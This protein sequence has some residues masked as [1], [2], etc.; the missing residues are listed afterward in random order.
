MKKSNSLIQ[1]FS[2]SLMVMQNKIECMS[3]GCF[4]DQK[5]QTVRLVTTPVE[6]HTIPS[7]VGKVVALPKNVGPSREKSQN[8]LAYLTTA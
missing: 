4:Y 1:L 2:L 5:Y 6:H 3:P 7:F 8:A